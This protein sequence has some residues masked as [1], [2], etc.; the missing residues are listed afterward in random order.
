MATTIDGIPAQYFAI[1]KTIKEDHAKRHKFDGVEG[2]L[3]QALAAL[4]RIQEM[5]Q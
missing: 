4:R 2:D 1:A 5:N 3:A